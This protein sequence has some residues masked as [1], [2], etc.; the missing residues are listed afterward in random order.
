MKYLQKPWIRIIISLI[1]GG[2]ISEI[3]H[4]STGD[5]NRPMGSGSSFIVLGSAFIVYLI[6]TSI[7]QKAK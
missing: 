2:M 6:L 3:L 1:A 4:I 5:P 7:S